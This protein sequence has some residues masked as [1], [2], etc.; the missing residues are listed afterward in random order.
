MFRHLI[1]DAKGQKSQRAAETDQPD[2]VKFEQPITKHH[3]KE[4]SDIKPKKQSG[5]DSK[6]ETNAPPR[7]QRDDVQG[8]GASPKETDK[9]KQEMAAVI[10]EGRQQTKGQQQQQQHRHPQHMPQ[11]RGK[12][13]R[14]HDHHDSRPYNQSLPPRL[15]RKQQQRQQQQ[16]HQHHHQ[17]HHQQ[18]HNQ[19][20]QQ[21]QVEEDEEEIEAEYPTEASVSSVAQE[22]K[23]IV[24]FSAASATQQ[25]EYGEDPQHQGPSPM[26]YPSSFSGNQ[27]KRAKNF[28][29]APDQFRA[30]DQ[31]L[32]YEKS[33]TPPDV[34]LQQQPR[35]KFVHI[36]MSSHGQQAQY[37]V[38]Q[39]QPFVV[40]GGQEQTEVVMA[41]EYHCA[42]QAQ[43][44]VQ[45]YPMYQL[46]P[47]QI[48][49]PQTVAPPQQPVTS[50]SVS[51]HSLLLCNLGLCT[52]MK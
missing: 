49:Q 44:P 46:H 29:P 27:G 14:R 10:K 20:Q 31:M 13:S 24:T 42:Q 47:A 35:Q 7:H 23:A 40:Q 33:Y 4:E 34:H 15:Q 19:E 43:H 39:T 30:Q 50:Q 48:S 11:G 16:Q 17:Q 38:N 51:Q 3:V 1:T 9:S 21:L 36:V 41:Q 25:L 26:R 12:A 45:P 37:A 6:V 8:N 2:K 5:Q 28:R 32:H 52:E 18:L 22:D